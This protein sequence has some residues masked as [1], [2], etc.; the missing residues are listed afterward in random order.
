MSKGRSKRR[1]KTEFGL[2][3][4]QTKAPSN[5]L[6]G[7][8]NSFKTFTTS[9]QDERSFCM[10]KENRYLVRPSWFAFPEDIESELSL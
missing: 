8:K 3:Y 10:D 5:A 7:R 6:F 1:D 4:I 9:V 2:V